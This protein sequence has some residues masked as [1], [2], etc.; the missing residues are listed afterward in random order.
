MLALWCYYMYTIIK[1]DCSDIQDHLNPQTTCIDKLLSKYN[2]YIK[3]LRSSVILFFM[4]TVQVLLGV[5]IFTS[6]TSLVV[7]ILLRK[8][9][10]N[11]SLTNI[12]LRKKQS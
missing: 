7:C 3:K 11:V 1:S 9:I 8:E 12:F 10:S 4:L 2:H 5:L 6:C